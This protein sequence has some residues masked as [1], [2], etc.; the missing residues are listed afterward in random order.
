MML[1]LLGIDAK[2]TNLSKSINKTLFSLVTRCET[3]K[4]NLSNKMLPLIYLFEFPLWKRVCLVPTTHAN[5]LRV[6]GR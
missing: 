2:T 1:H 5:A 3:V 6:S 4:K